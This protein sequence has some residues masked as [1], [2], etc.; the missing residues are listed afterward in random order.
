M[1]TLDEYR[2]TLEL[3]IEGAITALDMLVSTT[4]DRQLVPS[5]EIVDALLDIRQALRNATKEGLYVPKGDPTN[6]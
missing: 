1:T 4:K 6:G 2:T 3:S 5:P